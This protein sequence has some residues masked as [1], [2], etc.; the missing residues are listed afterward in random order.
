MVVTQ[1]PNKMLHIHKLNVPVTEAKI[2]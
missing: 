1:I 2:I